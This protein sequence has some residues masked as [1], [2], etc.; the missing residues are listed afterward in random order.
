MLKMCVIFG[1]LPVLKIPTVSVSHHHITHILYVR[2]KIKCE[3]SLDLRW[4]K[5]ARVRKYRWKEFCADQHCGLICISYANMTC[6]HG[7]HSLW[8]HLKGH[9]RVI[10][11]QIQTSL[12]LK[13][14]KRTAQL[15]IFNISAGFHSMM[16]SLYLDLQRSLDKH[17]R[18]QSVETRSHQASLR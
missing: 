17:K 11:S 1:E 18:A 3:A 16:C 8:K 4:L 6:C 9:S 14:K 5:V 7:N 13:K 2:T 10:S 15:D 12:W